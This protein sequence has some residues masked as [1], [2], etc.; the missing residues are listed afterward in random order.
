MKT[1]RFLLS[2]IVPALLALPPVVL[3]DETS[4]R[5][6]IARVMNASKT[7]GLRVRSRLVVTTGDPE[8]REV[9]QLLIKIRHDGDATQSLYQVLWPAPLKGQTLMVEKSPD[10]PVRG[11][12]FEPPNTVTQLTTKTMARPFFGSSL[13][14][15]DLAEDYWSWPSQRI[16]GAETVKERM[17]TIVESKPPAD[18]ATAYSLVRTW[19]SPEL[20]LPLRVE[21]YGKAR[22]L[23]KTITMDRIVKQSKDRWV[24]ATVNVAPAGL[25]S[26]TVLE[27]SN[28]DRDLDLPT[29][30]FTV[31]TV[32]RSLQ[33]T[34]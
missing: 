30:D 26:H 16:V 20:A 14:I 6:L 10:R 23:V 13:A 18:L 29:E 7:S 5:E 1:P 28:A 2:L 33:S 9:K 8:R 19:I 17:C 12:L 21:K 11:Y 22:Q 27:G 3:A 34:H 15:E 25:D 32:R 4:A 31:E 24:A